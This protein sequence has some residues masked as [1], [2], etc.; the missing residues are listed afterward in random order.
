MIQRKVEYAVTRKNPF[1]N[2]PIR[3]TYIFCDDDDAHLCT[4][5]A[6]SD[7]DSFH[8]N[9]KNFGTSHQ[10][11]LEK[12]DCLPTENI[13]FEGAD[14]FCIKSNSYEKDNC[15]CNSLLTSKYEYS[16]ILKNNNLNSKHEKNNDFIIHDRYSTLDAY[17][18]TAIYTPLLSSDDR[19][20]IIQQ[21]SFRG[22][23]N[24]NQRPPY[25][26]DQ[27]ENVNSGSCISILHAM[28]VR[29]SSAICLSLFLMLTL[30]V[31]LA[32]FS[33][34]IKPSS[35]YI[36]MQEIV[37]RVDAK[38]TS[39]MG[40]IKPSESGHGLSRATDN[41]YLSDET[42]NSRKRLRKPQLTFAKTYFRN[43]A[44]L[45]HS[46]QLT[47]EHKKH[48]LSPIAL[49]SFCSLLLFCCWLVKRLLEKKSLASLR[50]KA[51]TVS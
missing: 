42:I 44:P 3:N 27:T 14:V 48:F 28:H 20:D 46:P 1:R 33:N 24:Q 12:V 47:V 5:D 31:D 16:H 30:T 36:S 51:M 34:L 35:R 18:G 26:R 29:L 9:E 23:S 13:A 17:H 32:V 39:T 7:E 10:N 8:C 25:F 45:Y 50:K 43:N 2:K 37:L 40:E 6:P 41:A 38:E 21:I 15:Q 19:C 22:E 49:L 11:S 4:F